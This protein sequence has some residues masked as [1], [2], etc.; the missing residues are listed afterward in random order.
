[1]KKQKARHRDNLSMRQ[2]LSLTALTITALQLPNE[3]NL[4]IIE[5]ATSSRGITARFLCVNL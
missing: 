2:T 5:V 4:L 1:M 3:W